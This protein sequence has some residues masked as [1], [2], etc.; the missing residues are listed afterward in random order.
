MLSKKS[1]VSS[2]LSDVSF[3][4]NYPEKPYIAAIEAETFQIPSHARFALFDFDGT[5]FETGKLQVESCRLALEELLQKELDID[6]WPSYYRG[7]AKGSL[8]E[9]VGALIQGQGGEPSPENISCFLK[10][11]SDLVE[12][13][14]DHFDVRY[15]EG[16]KQLLERVMKKYSVA[17]CT[18]SEFGLI[19][20]VLKNFGL[21]KTFDSIVAAEHVGKESKPNPY[22]YTLTLRKIVARPEECVTFEDS[23]IGA[24]AS[25][26][27]SILTCARFSPAR[28]EQCRIDL[29]NLSAQPPYCEWTRAGPAVNLIDSWNQV[30]I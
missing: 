18:T 1:T 13:N 30:S 14:F 28:K 20:T 6:S 15:V 4:I 5:L 26:S 11:R 8:E 25:R 12:R 9:A 22:P 16:A 7:T 19:S 17:L 27:A 21:D 23:A 10:L 29:I 24:V 2:E 3:Q